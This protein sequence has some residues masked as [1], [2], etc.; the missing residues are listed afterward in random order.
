MRTNTIIIPFIR[1]DFIGPMLDSLSMYGNHDYNVIAIDQTEDLTAQKENEH[2]THLWIRPYR[3][4]G[5]SKAMNL[6]IQLAQTPYI[7]LANDDLVFFDKRWWG[8]IL[9]TFAMD[10]R[11]IAVN[12]MSPKEGAW[13]YGLRDDNKDTWQPPRGYIRAPGDPN[14][15]VPDHATE[16]TSGYYDWLLSKHPSWHEGTV[17]DGIA[18]WCTVFKREGLQEIGLLDE[19]FYPGGGEDYDML[20][21]SYSCAW[22]TPREK[23]DERFHR[24]MVGTTRSWV[25]HHWGKSRQLHTTSE[26]LFSSRPAWN[27]LGTL[28]PDGNDQWGHI[29]KEG[30]KVPC[31]RIPDIAIDE[32]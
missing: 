28:W 12:P 17:C 14:G 15:I 16:L 22:P 5:F 31:Q 25:W 8:G 20:C 27:E 32:L 23:C 24:R 2:K 19:R 18:M 7:T 21:R 9:D 3:N 30:V 10:E 11:I 4:L 1:S 26:G 13:G 6:G 29:E